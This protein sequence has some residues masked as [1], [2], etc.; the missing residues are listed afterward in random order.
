MADIAVDKVN[1][2][3][4]SLEGE[5]SLPGSPSY[6]EAVRIWNGAVT[7]RPAVVASCATAEDVVAALGVAH[8]EG[9]EV[10]VRGGVTTTPGMHCARA[11]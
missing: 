5:V 6:D 10:S 9:L 1:E 7:R 11:G 3:R 2:L 4:N 8:S